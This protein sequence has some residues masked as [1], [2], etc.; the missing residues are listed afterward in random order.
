[1]AARTVSLGTHPPWC[2]WSTRHAFS[3]AERCIFQ[4]AGNQHRTLTDHSSSHLYELFARF[5]VPTTVISDNGTQI[6]SSMFAEFCKKNGIHHLRISPY[7][8]Q[9]NSQ[10]G[11]ETLKTALLK[12]DEGEKV[13]ESLQIF[14]QA[15]R[16]T[17]SRVL[18]GKT[19]S[20]LKIGCI[21][22]IILNQL[23]LRQP[24]SS[25]INQQQNDQ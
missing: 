7:H 18:N 19:P 13:C 3:S 1:M 15:H 20:Q 9:S 24:M 23:Q 8:P 10:P 6:S 11:R 21:M 17:P 16:I 5:G 2:C 22:R 12:I 4:V 25:I 14:L